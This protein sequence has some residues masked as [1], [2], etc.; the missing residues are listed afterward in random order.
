[1]EKYED[2]HFIDDV[3]SH[4]FD[5][6]SSLVVDVS[7]SEGYEMR[8]ATLVFGALSLSIVL[9]LYY[10]VIPIKYIIPLEVT[11]SLGRLGCRA[12][13]TDLILNQVIFRLLL[14]VFTYVHFLEDI[15]SGPQVST[16]LPVHG[17][18]LKLIVGT[19]KALANANSLSSDGKLLY[20]KFVSSQASVHVSTLR[21][22]VHLL[23][24]SYTSSRILTLG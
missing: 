19:S 23:Q 10:W 1:M 22:F 21:P 16:S 8:T 17:N 7:A 5:L 24:S 2:Y 15:K 11:I 4:N 3:F 13:E 12:Q 14:A 20:K 18:H 9:L 6:P